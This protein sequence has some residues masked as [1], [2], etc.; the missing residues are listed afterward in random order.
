MTLVIKALTTEFLRN[1]SFF[2][3]DQTGLYLEMSIKEFE[4]GFNI[5]NDSA[6]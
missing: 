6:K 3:K 5:E 2:I 4:E 1:A